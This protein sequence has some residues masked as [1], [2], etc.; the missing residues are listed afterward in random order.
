MA[1]GLSG[2]WRDWMRGRTGAPFLAIG[3]P[4]LALAGFWVAGERGLMAAVLALLLLAV[5]TGAWRQ[6]DSARQSDPAEPYSRDRFLA[7]LDS[8]L[9]QA[10][11]QG[12]G[13]GCIVLQFDDAGTLLDRYGRSTQTEVIRNLGERLVSALRQGDRVLR[14]EGGDLRFRSPPRAGLILRP[15]CSCLR[16]SRPWSQSR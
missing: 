16:A 7:E 3:G 12:M 1:A 13:T 5:A 8:R 9:M 2:Q 6:P 4:V 15:W 14:L 11:S 10:E